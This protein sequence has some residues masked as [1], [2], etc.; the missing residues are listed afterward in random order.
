MLKGLLKS[1]STCLIGL[2]YF[3]TYGIEF[4]NSDKF[5]FTYS[6]IGICTLFLI[7]LFIY[8]V[9][10]TRLFGIGKQLFIFI[11]ILTIYGFIATDLLQKYSFLAFNE[12]NIIRGRNLIYF[13]LITISIT[14]FLSPKLILKNYLPL[15]FFL[16]TLSMVVLFSTK[17]APEK[18]RIIKKNLV[19]INSNKP[20]S[21][22][23]ILIITDE[24]A[25]PNELYKIQKDSSLFDFS[26][27]LN[28]DGWVTKNSF[29]SYET[30]TIHSL[31]S[32]LNYNESKSNGYSK[33]SADKIAHE[34][35]L[36]SALFNQSVAK[37]I[38]I[39]NFGIFD[40]GEVQ[41]FSKLY[42]YPKNFFELITKY[43]VL[44]AILSN[45]SNLKLKGFKPDYHPIEEHNKFI[46]K[47]LKDSLGK[48]KKPYIAYVHLYM[49]HSPLKYFD[50]FNTSLNKLDT[51]ARY[52]AYWKFANNKIY[53]LVAGLEKNYKIILTGDHGF[54]A[55]KKINPHMTF[56]AFYGFNQEELKS[57]QNV[58]D[59]GHLL[60]PVKVK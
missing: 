25:S 2:P 57:I 56:S 60:I 9:P 31:G 35:L 34:F 55:D 4:I 50:E 10:K 51:T 45:T 37:N 36:K 23:V 8:Q 33:L 26:R 43:T 24:Y 7:D 13:S 38:K 54:R 11:F 18:G 1:P 52:I 19:S 16:L 29:F 39:L 53:T 6:I 46:L 22:P 3:F 59:L 44:P 49:P 42:Y 21:K 28:A 15:N 17:Q 41:P 14:P 5:S 40:I 12:N 48:I 58:Q 20:N 27:K 30:S 32:L 47:S